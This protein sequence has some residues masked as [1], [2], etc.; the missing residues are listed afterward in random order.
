MNLAPEKIMALFSACFGLAAPALTCIR[1]YGVSSYA[2]ERR[3][4]EIGIRLALRADSRQ[5][6]FL[7]HPTVTARTGRRSGI[8]AAIVD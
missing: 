2:A 3:T 4:Q 7:R 1:V 5:V 8:I 6:A